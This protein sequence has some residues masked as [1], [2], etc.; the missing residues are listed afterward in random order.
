MYVIAMS[1]QVGFG[2]GTPSKMLWVDGIDP[3]MSESALE[4][5]MTKYGKVHVYSV[6]YSFLIFVSMSSVLYA[7]TCTLMFL[8]DLVVDRQ[9]DV[10]LTQARRERTNEKELT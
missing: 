3:D 7:C 8:V 5:S 4:R 6:Q 10:Q 2:K 9:F 1:V